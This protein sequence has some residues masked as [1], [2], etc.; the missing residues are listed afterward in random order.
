MTPV[1]AARRSLYTVLATL[2]LCPSGAWAGGA[3]DYFRE[4]LEQRTN[5]PQAFTL[6]CCCIGLI[7]FLA[8][9]IFGG[10]IWFLYFGDR[11]DVSDKE[12]KSKT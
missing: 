4:F 1:A 11:K 9:T 8:L 7:V 6:M 5:D 2:L 3:E 12:E 10:F